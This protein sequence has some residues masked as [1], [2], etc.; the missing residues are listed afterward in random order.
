MVFQVLKPG[1]TIKSIPSLSQLHV[2]R[3]FDNPAFG[4]IIQAFDENIKED[5]TK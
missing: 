1:S 3:R 4:A 2:T 5:S